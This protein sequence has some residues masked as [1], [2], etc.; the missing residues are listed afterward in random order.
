M[1]GYSNRILRADLTKQSSEVETIPTEWSRKFLGGMGFASILLFKEINKGLNALGPGNKLIVAPGL[2]VG[3]GIPTASKT[4]FVAKSPLTGGFGKASAG[5]SIGPALKKAGY[6]LLVIE[7]Q[8][9]KPSILVIADDVVKVETAEGLW[10]KNVRETAQLL[11]MRYEGF[12]SLGPHLLSK[13]EVDQG[14]NHG[15]YT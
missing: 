4:I 3:T 9:S 11:K 5:A 8:S 2:F 6:D 14:I 10:G 1:K 7:G 15:K 13:L 12:S